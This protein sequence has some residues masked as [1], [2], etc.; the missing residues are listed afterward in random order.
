MNFWADF[1]AQVRAQVQP[2]ARGFFTPTENGTLHPMLQGSTLLL[3]TGYPLVHQ[4]LDDPAMLQLL[5]RIAS[6]LLGRP[7]QVRLVRREQAGSREKLEQ[8][9]TEAV[10][11]RKH[12]TGERNDA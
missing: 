3:Q 8:L 1:T 2:S 11:Q 7:L 5:G 10:R 12:R 9:L 4:I 6:G